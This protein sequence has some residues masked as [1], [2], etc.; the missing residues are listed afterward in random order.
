MAD[1]VDTKNTGVSILACLIQIWDASGSENMISEPNNP[2]MIAEVEDIEIKDSYKD[3]FNTATVRF[4]R[5]TVIRKTITELNVEENAKEVMATTED[6]GLVVT[7][8]VNTSKAKVGDFKVGQRIRI[9]LGYISD[10]L[11]ANLAK[12]N[13]TGKT[14]Y[15]DAG[16]LA[17]YKKA[18]APTD[19]TANMFDGYIVKC[20]IDEPIELKCEDLA[21]YLKKITCPKITPTK[22]LTVNDLLAEDGTYKL[23]KKSGLKLHP[24][25]KECKIDV[26]LVPIPDSLTVADVLTTWGKKARLY[27]FVKADDSGNPCI[28]VGRSYF[29]DIKSD[30]IL[31]LKGEDSTPEILFDYHVAENNLSLMDV[32]KNFLA[33]DAMCWES[34]DGKGKQYHITVRINPE[35]DASKPGSK[36][37]QILNETTLSKKAM[38]AGATVLSQSKDKV[39]LSSYNII[40]YSS[41]KIG[42]SHEDLQLEAIKYFESYN[43]NGIEGSLTIFG[44][45]GLKSGMKVHLYDKRYPAKNGYYLIDEV[46]TKFGV[47]GYRQTIKMPYCIS[48]D[49]NEQSK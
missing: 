30:S 34:I 43:A 19:G 15:N 11:I 29:S 22:S 21:S 24:K 5:G 35:Y 47:N 23:L 8:R 25:T 20:S 9:R 17:K 42:I 46:S 49:K 27:S 37:Y 13:S 32:D 4:P 41:S 36:K 45:L 38:K 14:I 3:L 40:P 28:A 12:T 16:C 7:T 44:D 2:I 33:V 6:N 10:P 48:R 31:K 39:D 18:L 26:G 1:S